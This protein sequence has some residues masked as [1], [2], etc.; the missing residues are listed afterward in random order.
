MPTGYTSIIEE[1]EV[2]FE[3]FTWRCARAFGALIMMR[4][5]SMDAPIPQKFKPEPYYEEWLRKA[6]E[7]LTRLQAMAVD[8]A[9]IA[10]TSE[11]EA[12]RTS[13]AKHEA[14][15]VALTARYAAL[16]AKVAD[17]TPPSEEHAGLKQFMIEQIDLSARDGFGSYGVAP[18]RTSGA[19]W[20]RSK[21]I[22]AERDVERYAKAAHEEQER[23]ASRNAWIDALRR[24][25]PPPAAKG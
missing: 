15:A 20:L 23:V 8:E 3:E 9:E 25:V 21:I 18:E 4:D 5:D 11:Y 2:S 13:W 7:E 22:E 19:V 10:A 1:R 16:R 17:W 12:A 24:S 6:Q 14:K